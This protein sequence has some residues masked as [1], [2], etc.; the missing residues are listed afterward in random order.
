M[1]RQAALLSALFFTFF[2]G[3]SYAQRS[4]PVIPDVPEED[5]ICFALYT[6][7][8]QVM[9]M[10][11]QLY[12]LDEGDDRLVRLEI[13]DQ[14]D[15]KE[16][17]RGQVIENSYNSGVDD[18]RSWTASFR[19]EDWDDSRDHDY[20][21]VHGE[22]AFYYGKIRKDP[23]D[24]ETI[25]V[26]AFT[27]NSNRDRTLRPDLIAN[28]KAQDPDLLFFSGD[29]SYDHKYHL[30]A[31]LLFG[32]QFGEVIRDRPTICIPDDHD[33]GQ[34]NLWGAEGKKSKSMAGTD[35]G[36]FMP[37]A[38]VKEVERAQTSHLPDPYDPEPVKQGIGVYYTSLKVGGIDFAIVEDRKFKTGP[39]GVVPQQGPRPDHINDPAY[40][41]QRVDVKGTQLLGAR[42]LHFLQEW[43]EEWEQVEMKAVLSATVFAGAAHIHHGE[44]LVADL[45]ANGWPQ[46]GRN[47]ALSEIRKSYAFMIGGDQHLATVVHHGIDDWNDAGYSFCVPSIVNFYPRK[48]LPLEEGINPVNDRLEHTGAYL[49]GFHNKVTMYAYANPDEN[50]AIYPK[51]RED[52]AWGKLAAGHGII[53]FNKEERTITMECWPRGVDVTKS[54]AAQF[55][56]WPVTINQEDNY[57]RKAVAWLPEV[58]VKGLEDPVIQVEDE[59]TGEIVYTLRINGDSYVPKVFSEGAFTLRIGDGGSWKRVFTGIPAG[60]RDR[61]PIKVK[62]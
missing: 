28:I 7:Q 55:P 18:A 35:G 23:V 37:A 44:R 8:D 25:V 27:G 58:R 39:E 15:W 2:F 60:S 14:G 1:K 47:R 61:K 36:Y 50:N 21:A 13:C 31:W 16:I 17:A 40:D 19:I 5:Q 53:R 4:I 56:G 43:G 42:Q 49:D 3:V 38:Y 54:D 62:L 51:W 29:Q 9:K 45:D 22:R 41:P 59:S 46:S 34:S 26:A 12:P 52:G 10:T 57:G 11:V 32:R 30:A 20:R 6:V 33:V 48:W 24:K